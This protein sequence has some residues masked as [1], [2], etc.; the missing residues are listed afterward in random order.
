[1]KANTLILSWLCCLFLFVAVNSYGAYLKDMP[2]TVYQPD[3]T[4]LQLF[5]S[6]DEYHNWLHDANNF[7]IIRNPSN[8]Y[9]VYAIL[10]NGTLQAG[11]HIVGQ[12]DPLALGLQ[13]GLNIPAWEWQMK[14]EAFEENTPKKTGITPPGQFVPDVS[15]TLNNLVVFVRFS[16]QSQFTQGIGVYEDFFNNNTAGANSM[17]NYFKDVSYNSMTIPSTFYPLPAGTAILSYQD[18]HPRAYYMPYDEVTNPDGYLESER[19]EREHTLLK[20]AVEY[21]ASQVPGSLNIDFDN[22][23]YVDNVCFIIK[24]GTTA[25]ST[26]LWPHRW[27]LYSQT[28][29]INGKRVWDYNFQLEDFLSGSGVGVLAHEM[30]HTMGCPDLYHYDDNGIDPVGPWDL[31][32]SNANPPQHIGAFQKYKYTGWISSIPQITTS[33]TYT[34]NPLATATNNVFRLNTPNNPNEYFIFEY[35]K[36]EGAFENSVPGSGLLIYRINAL[37]GNG[38]ADGPPDEIYVYRPNGTISTNGNVY[39]AHFSLATGRTTFNNTTNPND[40]LSDGVTLGDID[41]SSVTAAG[42]TISF[43]VTMGSVAYFTANITETCSYQTILLQDQSTGG[44]ASWNWSF[45]PPQVQFVNGTTASSQHP[46]VQFTAGGIY[47]VTLIISGPSGSDTLTREDYISIQA[48]A[49]PPFTDNFESGSFTTKNWTINNPD[50]QTTWAIYSGAGGNGSSTKCAYMDNYNY[51]SN[52]QTDELI[53]PPVILAAGGSAQITFKVAYRPYSDEYHDTLKVL[54]STDCG[55][56]FPYILYNKTGSVLATGP[57]A[58]YM[59]I[60]AVSTDWR[61]ENINLTGYLGNTVIL[62]FQAINGYGNNLYIDDINFTGSAPV[63]AN[64]SATPTN[65]C[66]YGTVQFTDLSSGSPTSWFWTFGDGSTS[67]LQNPSHQ[68]SNTGTYTVSLTVTKSGNSNTMTKTDYITVNPLNTVSVSIVQEPAGTFCFGQAVT[69]T[70]AAVNGGSNPSYQWKRNAANVGGNEPSYTVSNLSNGEVISCVLTSNISCPANNPAMSNQIQVSVQNNVTPS[71]SITANPAG[72]ICQGTNVTFTANPVNGGDNPAY[73]WKKNGQN[74]GNNQPVFQ[75]GSLAQGDQISCV[76]T[77]ALPCVT[78]NPVNSNTITMVVSPPVT[79]GLSIIS[80]PGGA[81]CTGTNVIFSAIPQFPGTSPVYQWTVNGLTVGSNSTQFSSPALQN[82]DM[83]QCRMTSNHTCVINNPVFSNTIVMTVGDPVQVSVDIQADPGTNICQGQQV[84]FSAQVQNGGPNPAYVWRKNGILASYNPTYTPVSLA[85]GDVIRCQVTSNVVCPVGNPAV[86]SVVM[87]VNPMQNLTVNITADPPG[88]ICQDSEVMFSATITNGGENPQYQWLKNGQPVSIDPQYVTSELTHGDAVQCTVTSSLSCLYQNPVSSNTLNMNVLP[89]VP[90]SVS[91]MAAP[92]ISVCSG[93]S[94]TFTASPSNGGSNPAYQ[95]FRNG[96]PAGTSQNLVCGDPA[97]GE[98]FWCRLTSSLEGCLSGNPALS[99]T[100]TM[101]VYPL[102]QP[103]L[104]NDTTI[105]FAGSIM[106]DAGQ[107]YI[108]YDWNTGQNT[109]TILVDTTGLYAVTVTD[110]NGCSNTDSR[111]VTVGDCSLQGFLT[112]LNANQTPLNNSFISL[113]Q[114]NTTMAEV[115][116]SETGAYCFSGVP[117]G[118]YQ[119]FPSTA[120]AWGGVNAVDALLILRHFVNLSPL[121]GLA[122]KAGNVDN[123][124]VVN[125]ID[126]LMVQRRAVGLMES[127]PAGDW[128]FDNPVL[129]IP[130]SPALTQDLHGL[131]TGDVNGSYQ[132]PAKTKAGVILTE[133]DEIL[134]TDGNRIVLPIFCNMPC[135]GGA[136]TLFIRFPAAQ[137]KVEAVNVPGDYQEHL[138]WT[139]HDDVLAISRVNPYPPETAAGEAL[140][141]ITLVLTDPVIPSLSLECLPGSEIADAKAEIYDEVLLFHPKIIAGESGKH[142]L[143]VHP[144]PVTDQS[145][146]HLSLPRSMHGKLTVLSAEGQ[147]L[148]VLADNVMD[149]GIHTFKTGNCF[150]NNCSRAPGVYF[151]RLETPD[152]ISIARM[153]ITR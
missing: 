9:Y 104:G 53:M 142:G 50:G 122:L 48:P 110:A 149:A 67:S 62:K 100:L 59:F 79:A 82:G 66:K 88:S 31:M 24:G 106:L 16:D 121:T 25:W 27:S 111:M 129:M 115:G 37:A 105:P 125:T 30:M 76:M 87:T 147:L 33:G 58:T 23:N 98:T 65:P 5:A 69:F 12:S 75:T 73:Q 136:M 45:D 109:Q 102:P 113:K 117:A 135:E 153:I 2:V 78:S 20:N 36:K 134:E 57:A 32:A 120:K 127:F 49:I 107:G 143:S 18:S 148:A 70:A 92:G 99:D 3:G 51:P 133:G 141:W 15:G 83:V 42:S 43:T 103:E 145:F 85:N 46:Q 6:G 71:V 22:D 29:Y 19:T 126:A 130:G 119:V 132:V 146:I 137:V 41:I 114:G 101:T 52:P 44:P 80:N 74:V 39:N 124:P 108:T 116:T 96:I 21:I 91:I 35:R 152:G 63:N 4:A 26:L 118:Q 150:P 131:T 64:F 97:E 61:T 17:I 90:V 112:Y 93:S 84:V 10:V 11:N 151:I 56:T 77:S 8:G 1:M 139:S 94:V 13:P 128:V 47:S 40:F 34:L 54:L 138:V 95:W 55:Q 38:N 14:R 86:D 72:A 140:M 68:Y 28:V 89:A 60:P 81:I 144:N 7:T 123:S